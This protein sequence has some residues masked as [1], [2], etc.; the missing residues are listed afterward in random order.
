VS[1]E[2]IRTCVGCRSRGPKSALVR[3]VVASGELR[4]DPAASAS[5]RG[6]YVHPDPD[7]L[8][9]AGRAGVL[10]RALRTGLGSEEVGRLMLE[11]ERIGAA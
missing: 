4:V 6:A 8:A 10:G 11:V 7:C 2:P 9:D 1:A 5:G 3:V